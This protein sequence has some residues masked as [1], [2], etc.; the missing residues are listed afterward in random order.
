FDI[1]PK[2]LALRYALTLDAP[3]VVG[4]ESPEQVAETARLAAILKPLSP[5]EVQALAT[6]MDPVLN[7]IILEPWRWKP[8]SS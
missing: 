4:A 6:A 7:E 5:E 8:R 1:P 2:A 3:L